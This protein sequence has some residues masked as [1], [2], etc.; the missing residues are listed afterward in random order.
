MRQASSMKS[1]TARDL[2]F[3]AIVFVIGV[4]IVPAVTP[5]GS[6]TSPDSIAY[7]DIA[8][9]FAAGEWWRATDFSLA[10]GGMGSTVQNR[11]WP[12][13][14]PL[15]LSLFVSDFADVHGAALLSAILCGVTGALG[16]ALLRRSLSPLFAAVAACAILLSGPVVTCFAYAWSET[17]FIPLVLLAAL[18]AEA[19]RDWILLRAWSR[20]A[21]MGALV[22]VL[23][24]AVLSR[25]IG[26]CLAVLFPVVYFG[27]RRDTI[28]RVLIALGG[29]VY[30]ALVGA[31]LLQNY[32]VAGTLSGGGS[33]KVR[34]GLVCEHQPSF[35]DCH[36][37]DAKW[38]PYGRIVGAGRGIDRVGHPETGA[39]N[40]RD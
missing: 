32:L 28:D 31:F 3:G 38:A 9:H 35:R 20:V 12:P 21:V 5:Y 15:V 19:Y 2:V 39:S 7:L 14:Y 25:Y 13:L 10:T 11:I 27:S 16:Y 29:L 33:G 22:V 1:W 4:L 37:G 8:T 30:A 18:L 26:I 17:V 34:T 24:A 40:A 6:A 36:H 23:I